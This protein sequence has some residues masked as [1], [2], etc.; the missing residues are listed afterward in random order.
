[1]KNY[2]DLKKTY[3]LEE[4]DKNS[5]DTYLAEDIDYSKIR[6]E[7]KAAEDIIDYSDGSYYYKKDETVGIYEIGDDGTLTVENLPMGKFFVK[8]ISTLEGYVLD[9]E[10]YM[11][12][13]IQT[14]TTT[15]VYEYTLNLENLMTTIEISKVNI[16]DKLIEGCTLELYKECYNENGESY[17]EL[18]D[19]WTTN[20]E[21]HIVKGLSVNSKCILK[22]IQ[23]AENY[24]LAKD[25]EFTVK[26]S[27]YQN[28]KMI[29]KQV[30]ITKVNVEGEKVEGAYLQV[31]DRNGK[32]IDEWVSS[33]KTS[34][35]VSNLK[36]GEK[37]TLVELCAP[38]GYVKAKS[39]E[40]IVT[41]DKR[42]QEIVL[43]DK[44]V[45]MSK[46]D[47]NGNELEGATMIVTHTKT[48]NIVDKWIS[49]KEPHR[50]NNLIEGERLYT[51]RRDSSKWICKS[52]RY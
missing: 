51:S 40:F 34:H 24:V 5:E 35:Y 11:V 28:V 33:S 3:K 46:K 15:K 10:T 26:N 14:D 16:K 50:I 23:V 6:F 27:D 38:K 19:S 42:T 12:E 32:I 45:E 1:M 29:D 39:T 30:S 44:I 20:D 43:I 49:G 9:E 37:F 4:I 13:F 31:I 2:I 18:V 36:E 22:E 48:K 7:I 8:E 25:I 41:Y 21:T 17:F 52:Y 47:I